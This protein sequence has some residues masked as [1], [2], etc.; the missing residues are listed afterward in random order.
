MSILFSRVRAHVIIKGA[1]SLAGTG[2]QRDPDLQRATVGALL[3]LVAVDVPYSV[4]SVQTYAAHSNPVYDAEL[5]SADAVSALIRSFSRYTRRRDPVRRPRELD[6]ISLY[7]SV[8][9]GTRVRIALLRVSLLYHPLLREI[10][11]L[12]LSVHFFRFGSF[13]L[14]YCSYCSHALP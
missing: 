1:G 6:G 2:P 14:F 8:T 7:H 3:G 10:F 4:V 11:C 12:C 13:L 9:P 5:D